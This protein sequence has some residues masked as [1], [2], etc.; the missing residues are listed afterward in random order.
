MMSAAAAQTPLPELSIEPT[1][2]GSIIQIRNSASQPLTA[3]VIELVDYPGSF[4]SFWQDD[5][6]AP[7]APGE[8]KRIHV[9]NM[10]V[11][12]APD[13]VKVRAALYADGISSGIPEKVAQLVERRRFT[14]ETTRELI[15]RVAKAQSAGAAKPDVIA[16]LKQYAESMPPPGR[17]NRNSQAAINYFAARD[18]IAKTAASVEKESLAEVLAALRASERALAA[19]KP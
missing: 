14:L 1:A 3:Y 9:A 8:A 5:V 16:D 11:G 17:A 13:Y 7:I 18:L 12:A 6:A 15:R 4:F 2:G 19:S 10:M